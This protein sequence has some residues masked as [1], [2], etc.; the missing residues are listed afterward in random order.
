M[1]KNLHDKVQY[2]GIWLDMNEISTFD[3]NDIEKRKEC[4]FFTEK[5][6]LVLLKKKKK[7]TR[8]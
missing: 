4:E 2:D 1:L 3:S 6:K 5:L 7:L 8:N